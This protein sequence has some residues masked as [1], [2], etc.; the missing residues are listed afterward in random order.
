MSQTLIDI[1]ADLLALDDLIYE[2]SGD[3][4]NPEVVAA[5]ESW[6]NEIA[7][8]FETKA[9]HYAALITM[10][11]ARAEVRKAESERLAR[12]ARTDSNTAKNLQERLKYVFINLKIAKLDTPRYKLSLAKNGGKLPLRIE[13]PLAELPEVYREN[14]TAIEAKTDDIRAALE[15]GEEIKGCILEERGISLRIK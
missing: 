4:Q 15:R 6:E 9:D 7:G 5:L 13:C 2:H 1:S 3:M 11:N 12:L 10:L 8:N 14:V